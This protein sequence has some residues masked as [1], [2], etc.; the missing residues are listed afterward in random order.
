MKW[1]RQ[2]QGNI[3]ESNRGPVTKFTDAYL[4]DAK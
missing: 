4:E 1:D 3:E 2:G